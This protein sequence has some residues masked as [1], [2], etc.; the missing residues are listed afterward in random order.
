MDGS[1][2]SL[3]QWILNGFITHLRAYFLRLPQPPDSEIT[4]LLIY[5]N[6]SQ[7]SSVSSVSTR[8][9]QT[10]SEDEVSNP[11]VLLRW[12]HTYSFPRDHRLKTRTEDSNRTPTHTS[13]QFN[14]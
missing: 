6:V 14:N 1:N 2:P 8:S 3:R 5:K 7:Q 11:F 12:P 9:A 13:D 10:Q 4:P